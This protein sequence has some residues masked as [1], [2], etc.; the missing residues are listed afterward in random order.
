MGDG[1]G[2]SAGAGSATGSGGM[3]MDDEGPASLAMDSIHTTAASGEPTTQAYH[4]IAC[5]ERPGAP[6]GLFKLHPAALGWKGSGPGRNPANAKPIAI[7]V[8]DIR[9][10]IW[11][12]LSNKTGQLKIVTRN[13]NCVGFTGFAE[14]DFKT[15]KAFMRTHYSIDLQT[16]TLFSK[17]WNWG[18][19]EVGE[20]MF[21]FKSG[22]QTVFE[23]PFGQISQCLSTSTKSSEVSLELHHPDSVDDRMMDSLVEIRLHVPTVDEVADS[24]VKAYQQSL[25]KKTD[26]VAPSGASI[27][28]FAGVQILM[29]RGRYDI[30]LFQGGFIKLH[31]MSYDYKLSFDTL[32][33]YSLAQP[34]SHYIFLVVSVDPPPRQGQLKYHHFVLHLDMNKEIDLKINMTEEQAAKWKNLQPQM[35]GPSARIVPEIIETVTGSNVTKSGV[36]RSHLDQHGIK[37]SYKANDGFIFPLEEA[38]IFVHKVVYVKYNEIESVE[39]ARLSSGGGASGATRTFD[40]LVTMKD[41]TAFQFTNMFR[42]EYAKLIEWVQKLHLKVRAN[43]TGDRSKDD[44]REEPKQMIQKTLDAPVNGNDDEDSSE[45]EDFEPVVEEEVPEEFDEDYVSDPEKQAALPPASSSEEDDLFK[46]KNTDK[47]KT[48]PRKSHK[49]PSSSASSTTTSSTPAPT[50]STPATSTPGSTPTS[51]TGTATTPS[52]ESTT[53]SSV[54][55]TNTTPAD[56]KGH[57]THR[58]HSNDTAAA[59]KRKH[60]HTHKKTSG[61]G[62]HKKS[63][64]TAAPAKGDSNTTTA[65]TSTTST[66]SSTSP[67]TKKHHHKKSDSG[68]GK[69]TGKHRKHH[70]KAT[71]PA[72][73]P[74]PTSASATATSGDV[75]SPTAPKKPRTGSASTNSTTPSESQPTS[76]TTTPSASDNH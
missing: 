71:T 52:T 49:K 28:L 8:T 54:Q 19:V 75:A 40:F 32:K 30:E 50:G 44:S 47:K 6:T 18:E 24:M 65:T 35:T 9:E 74:A 69:S 55:S 29:P 57:K 37:C 31:G 26:S 16:E 60:T 11:T 10:A 42:Q 66:T 15:I 25:A 13:S 76:S 39:F 53:Q 61:T 5:R 12:R 67:A 1:E 62:K 51:S 21:V 73:A 72:S 70:S 59:G 64:D 20:S 41:E 27:V 7:P 63:S 4:R 3:A 38:F 33:L 68:T 14:A 17:G 23:I 58:K 2:A 36:F 22:E 43:E 46:P 56:K 34:S 45:D 48:K